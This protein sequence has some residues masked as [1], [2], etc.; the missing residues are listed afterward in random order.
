MTFRA[1]P[2]PMCWADLVFKNPTQ[3]AK[4]NSVVHPVIMK[5]I[6]ER[7]DTI[8]GKDP[9]AVVVIDAALLIETGMHKRYDKLGAE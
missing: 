9:E 8:K 1:I 2:I 4:L 7:L 6:E 5:R 3:R